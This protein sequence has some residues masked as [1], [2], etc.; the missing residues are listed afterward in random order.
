MSQPDSALKK[1]L[2]TR[3]LDTRA[4]MH[5]HQRQRAD[6]QICVHL[7]RLLEERDC[8]D[9]AAFVPFRGE[10]NLMPALEALS[11]AGRRVWLPVVN[12]RQMHFRRWQPGCRMEKNRY[13]IPEPVDGRECA[14]EQLELVLTPLVAFS[15]NGTRLGMGAGFYDRTFAFARTD[16]GRGPWMVGMAYTMQQVDSLPA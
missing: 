11:E 9:M 6:R 12:G 2:R 16:P 8:L 15:N 1:E 14:P 7:L 3:L 5:P 10:P 13:G 4:S